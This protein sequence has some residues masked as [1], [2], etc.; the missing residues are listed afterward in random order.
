MGKG[1]K[2]F[3]YQLE[4]PPVTALRRLVQLPKSVFD[5]GCVLFQED[6]LRSIS[7]GPRFSAERKERRRASATSAHPRPLS[8]EL[9]PA[10]T[11]GVQ[12]RPWSGRVSTVGPWE[13]SHALEPVW[14]KWAWPEGWA[15]TGRSGRS[16]FSRAPEDGAS[17]PLRQLLK[18]NEMR[19]D[20]ITALFVKDLS[21]YLSFSRAPPLSAPSPAYASA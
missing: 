14:L 9:R 15:A 17:S 12:A 5:Y 8:A 18:S 20:L 3:F 11:K 6:S 7:H 21:I 10:R 1:G 19:S 2:N 16:S 13:T 4:V